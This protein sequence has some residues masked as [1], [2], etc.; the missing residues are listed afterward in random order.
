MTSVITTTEILTDAVPQIYD[1]SI[2]VYRPI[3]KGK[4]VLKKMHDEKDIS[5][6]KRI[7]EI[8]IET[9]IK[10]LDI[11]SDTVSKAPRRWSELPEWMEEL[12]D[13]VKKISKYGHY[14]EILEKKLKEIDE[15]N[16][17]IILQQAASFTIINIQYI[18]QLISQAVWEAEKNEIRNFIIVDQVLVNIKDILEDAKN[19]RLERIN[20]I[21]HFDL[22]LWLLLRL[23]GHIRGKITPDDLEKDLADISLR[24]SSQFL[25]SE[26]YPIVLEIL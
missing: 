15:K 13:V 6:I 14:F 21:K 16:R 3:T 25:E 8:D 17:E 23:W 11:M 7:Y 9:Q 4:A 12:N 2:A 26:E 18:R 20:E 22:S 10:I 24:P 19:S 1:S 5:I